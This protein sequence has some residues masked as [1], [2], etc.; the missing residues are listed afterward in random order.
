MV[1]RKEISYKDSGDRLRDIRRELRITMDLVSRETGISRSYISDFERGYRLPTAKYLCYLHDRYN[2]NLNYI[3]F[4][5]SNMFKL[6]KENIP[7]YFTYL[8]GA[9]DKLLCFMHGNLAACFS[10]LAYAEKYK[11]ENEE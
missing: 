2:V 7:P 3:F 9:I 4:G 8:Q 5:E 1:N 11:L 6:G 10:I